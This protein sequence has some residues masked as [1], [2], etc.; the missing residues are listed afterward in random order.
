MRD[1]LLFSQ[2]LLLATE[3]LKKKWYQ[4][5]IKCGNGLIIVRRIGNRNALRSRYL[6]L[7]PAQLY[8]VCAVHDTKIAE[9]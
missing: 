5:G 8:I 6:G 1:R 3:A 9:F 2:T 7:Q 4:N